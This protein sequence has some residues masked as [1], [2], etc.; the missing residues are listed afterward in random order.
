MSQI[1]EKLIYRANIFNYDNKFL[2][3]K[4]NLQ[5]NADL[6]RQQADTIL[7]FIKDGA[8]DQLRNVLSIR[9]EDKKEVEK[10]NPINGLQVDSKEKQQKA[11]QFLR[12]LFEMIQISQKKVAENNSSYH[13]NL[14]YG[15]LYLD[16]LIM[17]DIEVVKVFSEYFQQISLEFSREMRSI[18]NGKFNED[19][20]KEISSHILSAYYSFNNPEIVES[21]EWFSLMKWTSD[22]SLTW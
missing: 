1:L 5:L 3:E 7:E 16:G 15:L 4:H 18:M 12:A 8:E 10:E 14:L 13:N 22:F 2:D 21:S 20:A 11:K 6:V 9:K 19:S 17:M